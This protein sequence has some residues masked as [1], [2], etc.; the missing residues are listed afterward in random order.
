MFLFDLLLYFFIFEFL[1]VDWREFDYRWA[2]RFYNNF[3]L[4]KSG[5]CSNTF[6]KFNFEP[7]LYCWKTVWRDLGVNSVSLFW[8]IYIFGESWKSVIG[9]EHLDYFYDLINFLFLS[10]SEF[11]ITIFF[12]YS[13]SFFNRLINFPCKACFILRFEWVKLMLFIYSN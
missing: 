5:V 9:V 4:L 8:F 11:F 7:W 6:V 2:S 1:L 13:F 10:L 3:S 12:N